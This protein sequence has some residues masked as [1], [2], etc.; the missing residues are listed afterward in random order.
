MPRRASLPGVLEREHDV[1]ETRFFA[2]AQLGGDDRALPFQVEALELTMGSNTWSAGSDPSP[3]ETIVGGGVGNYLIL[4]A[5]FSPT[6]R[7]DKF[8]IRTITATQQTPDAVPEP[9]TLLLV[10]SGLLVLT[11]V[12]RQKA[13]KSQP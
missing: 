1:S 9:G 10:G 12:V 5:S 2:D 8:K 11:L 3:L 7:D 6:D 13:R 4:A